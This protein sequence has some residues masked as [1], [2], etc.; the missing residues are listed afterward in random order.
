MAM[1]AAR[2]ASYAYSDPVR[3]SANKTQA[4][5]RLRADRPPYN[6][7]HKKQTAPAKSAGAG[8]E[9]SANL[10]L[11]KAQYDVAMMA[12]PASATA[13]PN[14]RRAQ[15]YANSSNIMPKNAECTLKAKSVGP[16]SAMN[17]APE[18][19]ENGSLA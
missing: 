18:Y 11:L 19:I 5:H 1:A 17:S 4:H 2:A 10:L 3:N 15:K 14:A 9:F 8:S 7:I 12:A 16:K 13:T 6:A